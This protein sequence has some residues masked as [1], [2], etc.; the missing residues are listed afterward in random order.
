M[1]STLAVA[2]KKVARD[3]ETYLFC[4]FSFHIF[5]F[6]LRKYTG[7]YSLGPSITFP[8]SVYDSDLSFL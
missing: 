8:S 6:F 2:I 5:V 3:E 4:P 1:V 7:T